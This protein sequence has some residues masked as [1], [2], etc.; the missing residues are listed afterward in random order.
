MGHQRFS[1]KRNKFFDN[2]RG[3]RNAPWQHLK[4]V[5]GKPFFCNVGEGNYLSIVGKN[6]L[7]DACTSGVFSDRLV[8][9]TVL[10]MMKN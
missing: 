2:S 10:W 5:R 8:F 9:M 1:P 4:E 7:P 6:D 3:G